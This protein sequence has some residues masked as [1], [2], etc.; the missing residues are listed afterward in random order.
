MTKAINVANYFIYLNNQLKKDDKK[1][2]TNKKIQKLL[3]YAQAWNL[4]INNKPLF[5]E[6]IEAWIHG[7]AIPSVY[8]VFAPFGAEQIEEDV[9]PEDFKNLKA[10]ELKL[11]E[12]IWRI[13]GKY[14]AGYLETLSHSE[15]P[16]LEARGGLSATEASSNI[17]S[18]ATMREY[19]EQK[20]KAVRETTTQLVKT[21]K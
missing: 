3:Y 16:W 9:N 13:Y 14:D 17:I 10:E 21:K 19:Y 7:P 11:L 12:E 6:D 2:L 20:R 18:Q 4:V 1:S 5:Q 15:T 8:K